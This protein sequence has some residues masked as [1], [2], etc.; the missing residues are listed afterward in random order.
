MTLVHTGGEKLPVAGLGA[1]GLGY[2]MLPL[3]LEG[4]AMGLAHVVQD[5]AGQDHGGHHVES[6]V[7]PLAQTLPA[8]SQPQQSLLGRLQRSAK[9][10]IEVLLWLRWCPMTPPPTILGLRIGLH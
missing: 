5:A 9:L 8:R 6:T 3:L 2:L 4:V 10:L 7:I 1:L